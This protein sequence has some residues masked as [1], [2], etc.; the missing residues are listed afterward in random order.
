MFPIAGQTAGP[1]G[2]NFF[3]DTHGWPGGDK[4]LKKSIFFSKFFSH[5]QRRALQLV[6]YILQILSLRKEI[7]VNS[8]INILFPFIH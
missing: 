7:E 2:L 3:V 4:G 1:I 8:C 5:G 6:F